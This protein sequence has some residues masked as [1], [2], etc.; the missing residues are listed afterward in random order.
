MTLIGFHLIKPFQMS[1]IGLVF[2]FVSLRWSIVR[3][4]FI[5]KDFYII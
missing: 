5:N 1:F 2:I 3:E 4:S